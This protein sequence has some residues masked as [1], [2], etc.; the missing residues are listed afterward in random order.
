MQKCANPPN[1]LIKGR[2]TVCIQ[3]VAYN[4]IKMRVLCISTKSPFFKSQ[5]GV[6][7]SNA[8]LSY[9]SCFGGGRAS[10]DPNNERGVEHACCCEKEGREEEGEKGRE[11][12]GREE[13]EEEI[14]QIDLRSI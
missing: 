11:E 9:C 7:F 4:P 3:S 12:E 2:K 14:N 8:S 13:E 10:L 6:A 5:G 1:H